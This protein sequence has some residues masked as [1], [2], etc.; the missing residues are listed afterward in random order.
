[1]LDKIRI[2]QRNIIKV[3]YYNNCAKI[4]GI[5]GSFTEN[6]N[7]AYSRFGICSKWCHLYLALLSKTCISLSR[8]DNNHHKIQLQLHIG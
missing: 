6:D 2:P 4:I 8:V 3:L 5:H 7:G 1:M